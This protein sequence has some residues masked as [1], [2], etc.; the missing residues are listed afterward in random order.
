MRLNCSTYHVDSDNTF[1][2]KVY[3]IF[4]CHCDNCRPYSAFTCHHDFMVLPIVC[5]TVHDSR[6]SQC[7]DCTQSARIEGSKTC[8]CGAVADGDIICFITYTWQSVSQEPSQFRLHRKRP[9]S[10][11]HQTVLVTSP[12]QKEKGVREGP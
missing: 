5:H 12:V 2:S 3:S 7:K 11:V 6:L 8:D 4:A 1:D 10:Q 9:I